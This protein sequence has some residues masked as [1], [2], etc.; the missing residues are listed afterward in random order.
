MAFVKLAAVSQVPE[1]TALHVETADGAVAIYN[2]EG[3]FHAMDGICPHS[4]GPLGE[5]ALQGRILVC[6]F[7]AWG[8]DCVT[9]L[10]DADDSLRQATYAVKTENGEIFADVP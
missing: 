3:E 9:G 2:I 7:H 4:G 10:S 5:G 1:G 8:F 6:P